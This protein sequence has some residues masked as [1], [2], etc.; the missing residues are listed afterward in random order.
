[1]P[2]GSQDESDISFIQT[3]LREAQE[4]VNL[5]PRHVEVV[6]TLPR[7]Y[8][9]LRTVTVVT[10]VV[11]LASTD[12]DNLNLV[13]DPA[14]VDCL[15]W[16]PLEFFL[17]NA[18]P[19]AVKSGLTHYV[20]DYLDSETGMKHIIFG[21]TAQFCI[22]LS[23]IALGR[24]PDVP[25]YKPVLLRDVKEDNETDSTILVFA[26]VMIMEDSNSNDKDLT[27]KSKL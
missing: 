14:E 10:P 22:T 15:Y 26:L 2:G 8:T 17:T 20:F 6:C 4:E 23:A 13:P 9:S 21:V 16:V 5:D 7:L 18:K 3:A 24:F 1:M 25:L 11:A 27:S 19:M 12:T